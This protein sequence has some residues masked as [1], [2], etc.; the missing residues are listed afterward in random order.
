M[1]ANVSEPVAN[2][3]VV[4][5]EKHGVKLS[6]IVDLALRRFFSQTPDEQERALARYLTDKPGKSRDAWRRSFW[7]VFS[8]EFG[9]EDAIDNPFAPRTYDAY[10]TVCLLN[11]VGGDGE[12]H[13]PIYIWVGPQVATETR[14]ESR[15][16]R[17]AR[18][19]SPAA[20]AEEVAQWIRSRAK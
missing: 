13:E 15:Q 10:M 14:N 20:A 1:S 18:L 5:A 16:F 4:F 9:G 3:L 11:N 7:R 6:P 8:E 17:F 2:E 12:E 19:S